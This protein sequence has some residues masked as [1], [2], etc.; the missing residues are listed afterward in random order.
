M[1]T[2]AIVVIAFAATSERK[3]TPLILGYKLETI[4]GHDYLIVW[5]GNS[6]CCVIHAESCPCKGGAHT[7]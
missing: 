2:I 4:R 5:N 1:I 7:N 3:S 6:G